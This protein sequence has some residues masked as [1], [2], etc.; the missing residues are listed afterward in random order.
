M[1]AKTKC[2][3]TRKLFLEKAHNLKGIIN[4]TEVEA[5]PKVFQSNSIGW[6]I[7]A[8]II[9]QINGISVPVRVGGNLV[10]VGSK[11]LPRDELSISKEE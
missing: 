10:V 8:R 2:P 7:N 1:P 6:T 3:I 11:D 4:G 5:E 9:V